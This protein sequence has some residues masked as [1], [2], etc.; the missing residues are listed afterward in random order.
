MRQEATNI[1]LG[2]G[3]VIECSNALYLK[4]TTEIKLKLVSCVNWSSIA[5]QIPPHSKII[6]A[7]SRLVGQQGASSLVSTD[8]SRISIRFT[9]SSIAHDFGEELEDPS[10][11]G[12]ISTQRLHG[13]HTHSQSKLGNLVDVTRWFKDLALDIWTDIAANRAGSLYVNIW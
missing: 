8:G 4:D 2:Q 1:L 13:H 9:M 6:A 11:C 7:V 12:L 10:V 5:S 3:V